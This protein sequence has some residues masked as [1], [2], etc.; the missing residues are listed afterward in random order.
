[1]ATNR[2]ERLKRLKFAVASWL[3]TERRKNNWSIENAAQRLKEH[4]SWLR[5]VEE[6]KISP[7]LC[8][9]RQA[10]VVYRGDIDGFL[11]MISTMADRALRGYKHEPLHELETDET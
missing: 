3:K 2:D 10:M 1:M 6:G 11:M 5:K 9:V 8:Q 7:S 4:P